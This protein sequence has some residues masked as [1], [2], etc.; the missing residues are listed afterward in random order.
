MVAAD[1]FNQGTDLMSLG[2]DSRRC[3]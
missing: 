3:G 2:A 1:A